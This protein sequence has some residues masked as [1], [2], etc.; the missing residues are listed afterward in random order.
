MAKGIDYEMGQTNIDPAT[1]IRF[2][3]IPVIDVLQSWKSVSEPNYGNP[4]CSKC[5][6]VANTIDLAMDNVENHSE[7]EYNGV[8]YV[9]NDCK[10]TFASGE[11]YP[12]KPVSWHY[13][14]NAYESQQEAGGDIIITKSPYY[15]LTECRSPDVPGA[16]HLGHPIGD[17]VKAYCFGH[18]WF[19]S[20]AAPYPVFCVDDN[21]YVAL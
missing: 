17:G 12:E 18:G 2:G 1:G 15:T 6:E 20:H 19:E 4:I 5:G 11:A 8:E 7:W 3:M 10:Y 16:G 14:D 9:C 13:N 21:S